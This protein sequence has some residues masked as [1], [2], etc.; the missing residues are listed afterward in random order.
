M[1]LRKLIMVGIIALMVFAGGIPLLN[2]R[3]FKEVAVK[4]PG[5]TEV[6]KLS[7]YFE[8]IKGTIADTDVFVFKGQ[9]EGGKV[10][11][12]AGTHENEISAMLTAFLFLEN[13][14]VQKG[15]VYVIPHFNYSGSLGTQPGGGFPLYYSFKTPWGEKKYR[16]GDRGLQQ[17][18]QWPDPDV[19]VHYPDKQLLSYIDARNTNRSW[20]GRPNGFLA[21]RI[22]YAAMQMMKEEK[23]DVAIDLHEAEVM[24]PVTNCIVVPDK[25][26]QIALGVSM[27][28]KAKE[29]FENHLEPSPS[30]FRGLSHREIGDYSDTLPFLFDS[31]APGLDQITGPK[32]NE[33]LMTGKDGFILEASK[34]GILYVPYD[35]TGWSMEKRVGQ[36]A[37]LALEV[38][39][40]FSRRNPDRALEVSGPRYPEI[41]EKGLGSFFTD[42]STVDPSLIIYQ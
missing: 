9:E 17:L 21:E 29:K 5:I 19:Y 35:E 24:F 16:M 37:S 11:L 41:V 40:Q 20:P 32:T 42:P 4:G 33:L 28:V 13:L 26:R 39:K 3:N 36:H 14:T 22:T 15:T 23:I 12:M 27:S 31:P 34:Y 1:I 2:Q 18:D 30:S 10:L 38:I 8:G 7:K 6:F 25:S